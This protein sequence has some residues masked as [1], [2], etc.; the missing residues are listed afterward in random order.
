MTLLYKRG[1]D[2]RRT[3]KLQRAVKRQRLSRREEDAVVTSMVLPRDLHKRAVTTAY[4]L[5]WSMAELVR[6]AV[7]AWLDRHARPGRKGGRA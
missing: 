5:N 1:S 7:E 4:E 6:H 2:M 3:P